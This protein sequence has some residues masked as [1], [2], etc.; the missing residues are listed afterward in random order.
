MS[1]AMTPQDHE[2]LR[3]RIGPL[4]IGALTAAEAAEVRAHIATCVDC[5]AEARAMQGVTDEIT[6]SV[7]LIDPPPAVRARVMA[8]IAARQP[9]TSVAL[10]GAQTMPSRLPWLAAAAAIVVAVGLGGYGVQLRGRVQSLQ[11]QLRDALAQIQAG[12]QRIAQA[13]L[14]AAAAARQLSVVAA[15]D[16]AQVALKG[17][18]AAPRASAR[19]LWSR[20]RGLLFSATDLPPLPAGRTYQLWII[21]GRSAP[22]SDGWIFKPD[23]E[24]GVTALFATPATLPQPTAIAV[25]IEPDGGT[26]APTGAMQLIGSL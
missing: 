5:A 18:P 21:S 16:A 24:G 8:A 7:E 9:M 19:V 12:D 3:A 2:E 23:A 22:I 6:W 26:K 20:S 15:A 1:D 17:Q 4:L 14:A 10:R 13:R 11:R 25:T